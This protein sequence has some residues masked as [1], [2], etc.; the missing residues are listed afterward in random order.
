MKSLV[1]Q[2]VKSPGIGKWLRIPAFLAVC[3]V[4]FANLGWAKEQGLT[5]IELYDGPSGAAYVQIRDVLIAGKIEMRATGTPDTPMDHGFYNKLTKVTLAV[6]GVLERGADGVLRYTAPDGSTTVVVPWNAKFEHGASLSPAQLADQATLRGTPTDAVSQVP[7]ISRGV[8]LVF[9][10]APDTELAEYLRAKRSNSIP[11][12]EN[13]LSKYPTSGHVG[14]GKNRLA[15]LFADAGEKA[16]DKYNATAESA[17]PSYADLKSARGFEEQARAQAPDAPEVLKLNEGVLK[18][19]SVIVDKGRTEL[20]LYRAA[21]K[22]HTAGYAHLGTAKSLVETANGIASTKAGELLLSDVMKDYN[23]VESAMRQAESSDTAKQY[24]Q[25]LS[26]VAPY[27]SFQDEE[28]RIAA[29]FQANYNYHMERGKQAAALSNWDTA[30]TEFEKAGNAKGT[31]DAKAQ[32]ANARQQWT[33]VQDKTAAD[34]ARAESAS[35]EQEKDILKAYEVLDELPASQRKLVQD[36]LDRLQP[37]YVQRC[38][39]VAKERR[40]AHEPMRGL[41]DEEGI[42]SAYQ[43]LQK[44]YK[45]SGDEDLQSR[46]ELLSDE[47]SAYL[48]AQAKVYLSKPSGS[49]TELAWTYLSEALPYKASNLSA[50]RDAMTAAQAAHAVRSKLSIRVQFRDQTS[51]RDSQGLTGQL[52][53]A[54]INGLETSKV[55]V[56]VVRQGEPTPVGIEPDYQLV[57]DVLV[58]HL[59]VEPVVESVESKFLAGTLPVESDDWKKANRD[60]EKAKMDLTTAQTALQGAEAKGNKSAVKDLNRQVQL[61]EKEVEDAQTLLDKTPQMVSQDVIRPYTYTKKT[62]TLTAAIQ[63]QFTITDAFG[64]ERAEMIPISKEV[65]RTYTVLEGVRSDDT[66]GVKNPETEIDQVGF[67]TEAEGAAMN[68]LIAAARQRVEGLPKKIYQRGL[69]RENEQDL[70]GAGEFYM[71]FLELVP[72]DG[73]SEVNH[74]KKFLQD[75][76]NMKPP[77]LVPAQ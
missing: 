47:M 32:L 22:G 2:V 13:Y 69:T 35:Y 42:Q 62:V 70:D 73:S 51:Q 27:R 29:I 64:E 30:I 5:A 40:Q 24:D 39:Q 54:I 17:E 26:N 74:A 31:P 3:L 58:H 7:Q 60:Y 45:L 44:A 65:K 6:G 15:A 56:R 23:A 49:G 25:A 77:A 16:L 1:V 67:M 18:A 14:D 37:A 52:E 28:P 8:T 59:T 34:K 33:V 68:D 66:T 50:V 63:L 10:A 71:R 41:S 55:P 12:W 48:L 19:L 9:V 36:D 21:L 61:A 75:Q 4:S 53:N 43:Y 72:D 38:S 20:D 46:M 57:G 76:F 11:G